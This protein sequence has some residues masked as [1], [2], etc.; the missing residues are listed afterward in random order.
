MVVRKA[1][2]VAPLGRLQVSALTLAAVLGGGQALAQE[3]AEG[4]GLDEIIVVAQKREQALQDVPLAV[5]AFSA[6]TL[7][8]AQIEDAVDLQL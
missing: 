3:A 6:A 5:S 1:G 8:R 2:W 7:E 4:V